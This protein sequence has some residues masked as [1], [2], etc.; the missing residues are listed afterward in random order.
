MG[1]NV[2][3]GDGVLDE[4]KNAVNSRTKKMVQMTINIFFDCLEDK[5]KDLPNSIK[6]LRNNPEIEQRVA[7]LWSKQLFE[8]GLVPKTYSGLSDKLLVSN[9]RQEGY[10]DGMYIGYVLAMMALVDNNIA[11]DKILA[12]RDY[13][14]PNLIR[15]H[16]DDRD[17]FIAQYEN[18]RYSWVEKS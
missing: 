6:R 2:R 9:L 11:E 7:A 1:E 17:E 14:R 13:I 12:V 8:E 15:H 16:F 10:V 5:I 3:L 4:A 18:E